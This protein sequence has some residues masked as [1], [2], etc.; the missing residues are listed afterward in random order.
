MP[1]NQRRHRCRLPPSRRR[2]A[3]G[4]CGYGEETGAVAHARIGSGRRR[5]SRHCLR[6]QGLRVVC[7]YGCACQR[8]SRA[9]AAA[10][11]RH[12]TGTRPHGQQATHDSQR[13]HVLAH[14]G[15]ATLPAARACSEATTMAPNAEFQI[16]CRSYSPNSSPNGRWLRHRSHGSTTGDLPTIA[17]VDAHLRQ[18]LKETLTR[19]VC[20]M[21]SRDSV[22]EQSKS[23]TLPHHQHA[24]LQPHQ[25]LPLLT[26]RRRGRMGK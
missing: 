10:R 5:R 19:L 14:A 2:G 4:W 23:R 12:T 1:P 11:P 7:R 24:P 6:Q 17:A 25:H 13:E 9:C 3:S 26:G 15:V 18:P 22:S 21:P 8:I 20:V 16:C